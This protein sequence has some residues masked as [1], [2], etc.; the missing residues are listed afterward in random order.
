MVCSMNAPWLKDG[1]TTEMR[2]SVGSAMTRTTIAVR[3][4]SRL[5]RQEPGYR[6]RDSIA[7]AVARLEPE[8]LLRPGRVDAAPGLTVGLTCVPGQGAGEPDFRG[9]DLH[10]VANARLLA[11]PEVHRLSA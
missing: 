4:P 3:R 11:D 8:E 7:Q 9:H 10:E 2:G 1:V 6:L 5:L